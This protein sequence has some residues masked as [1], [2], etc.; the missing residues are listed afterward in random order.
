MKNILKFIKKYDTIIIHGHEHP[1]GDCIGSQLGLKE[2]IKTTFPN[3]NVYAV[4]ENSEYLSFMGELDNIDDSIYNNSL[5]IVVD[6]ANQDRASDKRF[7][8]S[9]YVIKIDHHINVESYANY[10]YV[11]STC[12]SCCEII[13]FLALKLKLKITSYAAKM[14]YT[15]IIT[16]TGRFKYDSVKPRTHQIAA[17]LLSYGVNPQEIDNNLSVDTLETLKLKG[18]VLSK[19]STTKEGFAY[20]KITR[21]IIE[22]YKVSDEQAANMVNMLSTIK[23]ILTWALV[24]EYEDSTIKVRIRSKAPAINELAAKYNGGGH[25]KASGCKLDT[26]NQFDDFVKDMNNLLKE[27]KKNNY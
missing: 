11:D 24:I 1:D 19:F 21:D 22:K 27:Y 15:G 20:I 9:N 13:A 26:W 10:E 14:L 4:G 12:S 18:Y 2:I 23:G 17:M 8:L 3:K 25:A 6:L 5:S 16:D 7:K